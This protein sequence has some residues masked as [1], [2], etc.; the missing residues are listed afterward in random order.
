MALPDRRLSHVLAKCETDRAPDPRVTVFDV[1]AEST[2]SAVLLSGVV[3]TDHLKAR[4]VEAVEA[5]T[6]RPVAATDVTALERSARDR[7]VTAPV[8]PVR[9]EPDEDAEQVT[10]VLYGADLTAYDAEDGWRRVRVP[11]GYVGWVDRTCV[12]VPTEISADAAVT[13]T[14][15]DV[16]ADPG[17]MYAGTECE[18][19]E[20]ADPARVRFRTGVEHS[21]PREAVGERPAGRSP[22]GDEV[23]ETAREYLGTEYVWGGMTVEGIDCSGLTWM[24]YRRNGLTLPR[25]AD[26]QRKMGEEVARGDLEPGDLLFFPGHVALSLGGERVIHAEGEAGEVVVDSLDPDADRYNERLDEGFEL[27]TRLV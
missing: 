6:D 11:D 7:T 14:R 5:A 10:Q 3:L 16:A 24:A 22:T 15:L 13:A 9:G 26:L 20:D 17:T 19:I 12:G 1:S 2:D 4:A 27:A 21:V 25:D 18:I 8:A 23:V